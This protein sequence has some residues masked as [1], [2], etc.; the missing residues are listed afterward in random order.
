MELLF[1]SITFML[2]SRGGDFCVFGVHVAGL[3]GASITNWY[4]WGIFWSR[5]GPLEAV[6]AILGGLDAHLG[7]F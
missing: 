3:D 4:V 6:M 7:A 2:V 5:L 1:D